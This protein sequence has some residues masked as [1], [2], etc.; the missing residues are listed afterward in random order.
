MAGSPQ[1]K[2]GVGIDGVGFQRGIAAIMGQVN[3]LKGA[4]LAGLGIG[5]LSEMISSAVEFAKEAEKA[6][7]ELG[8]SLDRA[9]QLNRIME[10]VGK[11]ASNLVQAS[12]KFQEYM[13]DA[14]TDADKMSKLKAFGIS[15]SDFANFNF[16]TA[17][18]K[19]L[20]ASVGKGL[21]ESQMF[22]RESMGKAGADFLY[23][24][25]QLLQGPAESGINEEEIKQVIE[26]TAQFKEL[27]EQISILTLHAI[28]PFGQW[29]IG[30][31]DLLH[32]G[33]GKSSSGFYSK[34]A[35][36][37]SNLASA[38]RSNR[39]LGDI[40]MLKQFGADVA[41]QNTLVGMVNGTPEEKQKVYEDAIRK[42]AERLSGG[43]SDVFNAVM[44]EFA[45]EKSK[46]PL[47]ELIESQK[48]AK[49]RG[50][51]PIVAAALTRSGIASNEM[52]RIGGLLGVDTSYRLNAAQNQ[53]NE[54]KITNQ[55]L[56]SIDNKLSPSVGMSAD[57]PL[58]A[59]QTPTPP[60]IGRSTTVKDFSNKQG[61]TPNA[62]QQAA[63]RE[64]G[65]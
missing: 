30:V 50:N 55:L 27:K 25:E 6:S 61:W 60:T 57:S 56:T 45:A 38:E 16:D 2:I 54:Q 46:S 36:Y 3:E 14:Y 59:M 43:N 20:A 1:I 11:S 5:A 34:Q 53:L 18:R 28:V 63:L 42:Y 32:I 64:A 29:L 4:L 24:R 17:L 52:V 48:N 37:I 44:K 9:I 39:G 26:L 8:V 21:T 65:M 62:A 41:L 15:E 13:K 12:G 33:G 51:G 49:D 35:D 10:S 31:M 58:A 7:D 22:F 40:G 19:T 47:D 23:K